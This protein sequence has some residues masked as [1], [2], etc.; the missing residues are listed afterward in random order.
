M[1]IELAPVAAPTICAGHGGPAPK[2]LYPLI[3]IMTSAAAEAA[4]IEATG[5]VA[6][7][8]VA[9]II[10]GTT[11]E[12]NQICTIDPP[13]DPGLTATDV[14]N[15]LNFTAPLLQVPAALKVQQWFLHWYWYIVC[16]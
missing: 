14:T 5:G 16:Q 2:P 6:S 7:L 8:A 3:V 9:A 15:A 4:L 10:A 1:A 12:L 13:P 11:F